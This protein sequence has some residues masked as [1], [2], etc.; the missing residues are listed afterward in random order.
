MYEA[1]E[2]IERHGEASPIAE[3][4]GQRV[5]RDGTDSAV[6]VV[7]TIAKVFMQAATD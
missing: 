2:P 3:F 5:V 1:R 4:N 6:G 7:V